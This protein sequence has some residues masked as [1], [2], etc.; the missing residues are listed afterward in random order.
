MAKEVTAIPYYRRTVSRTFSGAP[1][2]VRV[3]FKNAKGVHVGHATMGAALAL[4]Y[5][6]GKAAWVRL[7]P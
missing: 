4:S 3:Y 2:Q 6:P 1:Y 7:D 5:P